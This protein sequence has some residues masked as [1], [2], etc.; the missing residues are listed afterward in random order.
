MI[1]SPSNCTIFL[2]SAHTHVKPS[3][4]DF[5][6]W[7]LLHVTLKKETAQ[8][9][10]KIDH[11]NFDD[12]FLSLLL[13]QYG[14]NLRRYYFRCLKR[15]KKRLFSLRLLSSGITNV[16]V[17]SD[18]YSPM[19][20]RSLLPPPSTWKTLKIDSVRYSVT[21]LNI[22]KTIRCRIPEERWS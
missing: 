9:G 12:S 20:Q 19:F 21:L 14:S 15:G 22:C 11:G 3:G 13:N 7:F 6:F 18:R 5:A 8:H 10:E 16:T 2:S 4:K 17:Y 1:F